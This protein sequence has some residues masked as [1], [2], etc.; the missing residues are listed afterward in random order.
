MMIEPL[1]AYVLSKRL[2]GETSLVVTFFT[3]DGGL[4]RARCQGGRTPKKQALLQPFLPLWVVFKAKG[5]WHYV[6]QMEACH[7][8]NILLGPNLLAGLYVNELIGHFIQ[9]Q[10]AHPHLYD[11]YHQTIKQLAEAKNKR[12]IEMIL[13]P[14]E[15][16]L[17]CECGY[18]F[19]WTHD[20]NSQK[21]IDTD[22]YYA[23]IPGEGF[24][25]AINGILGEDLHAFTQGQLDLDSVLKTSKFIMQKTIEYYLN[26]KALL[27]RQ[28]YRTIKH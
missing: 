27:T 26:G 6:Q 2:V 7:T 12:Q 15:W 10:D 11:V 3:R 23:Y 22:A 16:S 8:A 20:V 5:Q 4:I 1:E 17:L 19:S 28:L 18:E 9:I 14:F 21:P 25:K 24:I 13:R